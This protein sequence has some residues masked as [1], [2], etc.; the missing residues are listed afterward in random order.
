MTLQPA[1]QRYPR[2][3]R[4]LHTHS[5]RLPIEKATGDL[6]QTSAGAAAGPQ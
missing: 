3:Q 4:Q 6:Q 2:F 1:A 5:Q